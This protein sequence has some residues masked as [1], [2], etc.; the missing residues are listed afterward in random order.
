MCG[1]FTF[2]TNPE[3]FMDRFGL[4]ELIIDLPPRYNIAPTQ[5]VPIILEINGQRIVREFRWGLIPS[6]ARDSKVGSKMINARAETLQQKPAFGRLLLSK[7]CIIPSDGF[8]EWKQVG[9]QKYPKRIT[10]MDETLFAMAGL[11]DLWCSPEGDIHQTFTIITTQPN[12][13]MATIHNRMPAIL[14]PENE[15]DWLNPEESDPEFLQSLLV[16]YPADTM[17]AYSVHPMV[18]N[19]RNDSQECIREIEDPDCGEEQ[20]SFF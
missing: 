8:F 15:A 19:P 3:E 20:L 9:E 2:V 14:Q 6:W 5:L 12:E 18:G 10:L 17:K 16:P 1:R 4:D 7:R 11:Y 13:L